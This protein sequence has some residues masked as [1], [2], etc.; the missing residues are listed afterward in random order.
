M[1][2]CSSFIRAAIP[3]CSTNYIRDANYVRFWPLAEMGGLFHVTSAIRQLTEPGYFRSQQQLPTRGGDAAQTL[4]PDT[5][6]FSDFHLRHPRLECAR[7][8]VSRQAPYQPRL[9]RGLAYFPKGI[10][11]FL[12]ACNELPIVVVLAPV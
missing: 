5:R 7:Q 2:T 1:K 4:P 10:L 6:F 11:F 8:R 12:S 3:I 9:T